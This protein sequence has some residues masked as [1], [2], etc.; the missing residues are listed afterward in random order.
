[1][2]INK[3]NYILSFLV[4]GVSAFV[5]DINVDAYKELEVLFLID[6]VAFKQYFKHISYESKL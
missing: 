3:K 2:R 6:N 4:Q 1:M 5:T